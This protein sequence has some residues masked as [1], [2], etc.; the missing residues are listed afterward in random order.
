MKPED[1]KL[2]PTEHDKQFQKIRSDALAGLTPETRPRAVFTGGQPGSGKSMIAAQAMKD[3]G[4]NAVRVDADELRPY[5]KDYERLM[6]AGVKNAPDLVHADAGRWAASLTHAAMEQ[7]YNLV[8]D[9]TMR[10]PQAIATVASR[11]RE[12]G[13]VVEGRVMA[14]N[15]LVSTL[16]VHKRYENQVQAQGVG[17]FSTKEQHDRA[18]SGLPT[19]LELLERNRALDKLTLFNRDGAAIYRNELVGDRWLEAPAARQALDIERNREMTLDEKRDLAAGWGA[20]VKQM[21]ERAAPTDEIASTTKLATEEIRKSASHGRG[22]GYE[23]L[24]ASAEQMR[25]QPA[26]V[27]KF[28]SLVASQE[29]AKRAQLE[30]V[31]QAIAKMGDRLAARKQEAVSDA[32]PKPPKLPAPAKPGIVAPKRN[33]DADKDR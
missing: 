9:G 28:A 15:E 10:D 13:Y 25:K 32:A 19:S 33:K 1:F 26:L 30:G 18:Y 23:K 4:Y 31:Q 3:F 14:V 6:G 11:L 21:K 12:A 16:H 29:G 2:S 8:I 17:R 22:R 7:R 27:G 20:V 24:F 5:H